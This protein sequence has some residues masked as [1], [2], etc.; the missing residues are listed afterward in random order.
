MRTVATVLNACGGVAH[1]H[2]LRAAG[3]GDDRIRRAAHRG[4]IRRLRQS[5]YATADAHPEILRAAML[6]G[7]V[8]GATA[9]PF[10]HLWTPPDTPFT[11]EVSRSAKVAV[12]SDVRVMW[13]RESRTLSESLG[14]APLTDTIRQLA[15][16]QPAPFVVAV[17]DSA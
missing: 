13:R 6:G 7:R 10:H 17:L 11:I 9:A 14:V 1:L 4:E 2:T 16:T 8:A 3:L 5:V 12:P 15:I